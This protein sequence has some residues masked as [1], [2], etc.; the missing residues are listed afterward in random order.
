VKLKENIV[1][2]L[3]AGYGL[4][5]T[6]AGEKQRASQINAG[7][8][9]NPS[10][11]FEELAEF[12]AYSSN[13]DILDQI[14]ASPAVVQSS[15]WDAASG[16]SPLTT[17]LEPDTLITQSV[18]SSGQNEN[19][20][21]QL[22]TGST[23]QIPM[24]T[25][26]HVPRYSFY[27]AG[28]ANAAVLGVS[29]ARLQEHK[30]G[31]DR[32]PSPWADHTSHV[33]VGELTSAPDLIA[34]EGQRRYDHDLYIDCLPFKEFR[35]KLL[36]LRSVEPK[37]FDEDD[38]I[39]DLDARDAFQCWGPTPWEDRSWEV[40]PWFLQKWWMITGGENGEMATASRWWRRFRGED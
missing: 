19:A 2:C 39:Q 20:V 31:G 18:L 26:V 24:D 35:E 3:T 30:C 36:A 40:Q 32:M 5:N 10:V 14:L 28:V 7:G 13:D 33:K 21:S 8:A 4:S 22:A 17:V 38:F 12:P 23:L 34:G 1:R 11:S 9:T 25:Y 16:S 27:A 29:F 15:M 6:H 37:I